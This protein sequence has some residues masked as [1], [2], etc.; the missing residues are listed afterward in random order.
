MPF[1]GFT[2]FYEAARW[3]G[4][5][6]A[7]AWITLFWWSLRRYSRR[8]LNAIWP[9]VLGFLTM[10]SGNPYGALGIIIVLLAIALEL[11]VTRHWK[12]L[13]P[14]VILGAAVGLTAIVVFFPL[15]LSGA[16]TVRTSS[17]ISNDMFL[18]PG[19]GDI[20][21]MSSP[22][23]RPPIR[24]FFGIIENVPSAYLAWFL[25]PLLPWL[26]FRSISRRTRQLTSLYVIT[27]IYLLVSFAPSNVLTFRWPLRL[28]EYGYLGILVIFV[29]VASAGLQKT[30]VRK[31]L[32]AS[33]VIVAFGAYRAWS[34][35]P[36]A[37]RSHG[38]AALI[39]LVFLA[40]ALRMW[41]RSGYK[42]LGVAVTVGTIV[43]LTLQAH[44][45]IPHNPVAGLGSPIDVSTLEKS[46]IDEKG[47]TLQVFQTSKLSP[48]D[49]VSG[50]F[51]YGN[52][53]LVGGMDQSLNRYSGISFVKF[54]NALC[55]NYRGETCPLAYDVLWQN[56]S[57]DITAPL[58]DSLRLE[59][60]TV[61]K[62]LID[63]SKR[64][65]PQGWHIAE[66]DESRVILRRDVPL[67]LPGDVSWS[68]TGM[69]V[70]N[71]TTDGNNEL[72][73][74]SPSTGNGE[75]LFAR[76][77]WPGYNVQADS[78]PLSWKQ[79]PAGLLE[80]DVPAGTS[81]V[82]IHYETPGL[83]LGLVSLLVGWVIALVLSGVEFFRR[84]RRGNAVP[85]LT[86]DQD[87]SVVHTA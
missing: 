70:L 32:L 87:N 57:D 52:T 7:L 47:N 42:G 26:S 82:S 12:R 11:M 72:V 17:E 38:L 78:K 20:F 62:A 77:A 1:S 6:A 61:Q 74:L 45:F 56:S 31:R 25:L 18:V 46:T 60:V 50:K 40:A 41:K 65:L 51:L 37:W 55:M 43:V 10:T 24:T 15:P 54:V 67:A 27:A 23:Y 4:G 34:I 33:G 35:L 49:F 28:L 19:L 63:L 85:K 36:G 73:T 68:S 8:R 44:L 59:T 79:G 39:V 21:A 30:H 71:A 5:L 83:T 48:S 66:S 81:H 13:V 86:A 69:H 29:C 14:L 84:R 3:P 64:P 9:F 22:S 2:L 58:A 16:V 80:V 53:V 75:L 76:L